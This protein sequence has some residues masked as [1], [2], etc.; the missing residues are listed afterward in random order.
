VKSSTFFLGDFPENRYNVPGVPDDGTYTRDNNTLAYL[1]AMKP[2]VAPGRRWQ[3][4]I[5][6]AREGSTGPHVQ[7][8]APVSKHSG[9]IRLSKT[10]VHNGCATGTHG[11]CDIHSWKISIQ[12]GSQLENV[13][14]AYKPRPKISAI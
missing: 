14:V 1:P 7:P 10:S 11:S 12:A 4:F 9:M 2:D 8:S 5:A 13:V 6:I 3:S